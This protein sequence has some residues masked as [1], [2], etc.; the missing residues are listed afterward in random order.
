V[1][2]LVMNILVS[3]EIRAVCVKIAPKFAMIA[4]T[5]STDTVVQLT[6]WTG[7]GT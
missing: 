5:I 7:M 2:I 4:K 3:L 6:L 1:F